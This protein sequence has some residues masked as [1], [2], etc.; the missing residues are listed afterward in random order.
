MTKVEFY[1]E[2]LGVINTDTSEPYSYQWDT[3]GVAPGAYMIK[4]KAY[5]AA[6]NTPLSATV[7]MVKYF[8]KY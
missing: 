3:A 1:A 5:D 8:K 2:P 7:K 4:A 6:G